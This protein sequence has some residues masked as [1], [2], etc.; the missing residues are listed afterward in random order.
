MTDMGLEDRDYMRPGGASW[1]T[2]S[3]GGR[4]LLALIAVNVAA[5]LAWQL[6][7][8]RD[9]LATHFA[10]SP[11]GLL[12]HGRVWTL[13]TS[14]FLHTSGWYLLWSLVVA[15][16]FVLEIADVYGGRNLVWLYLFGAVCAALAQVAASSLA[17]AST[18]AFAGASGPV[19]AFAATAALLFPTRTVNLL[20]MIP[21][22]L[23]VVAAAALLI[24]LMGPFEG[25]GRA[26]TLG[27]AAAGCMFKVLDLR[28]FG[29]HTPPSRVLAGHRAAPSRDVPLDDRLGPPVAAPGE[30]DALAAFSARVDDVLRKINREGL[31][32]LTPDERA[33][34]D[35][36]SRRYS[37][38]HRRV[39]TADS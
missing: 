30:D 29:A 6:P 27:G 9:L 3:P 12:E 32:S 20:G 33:L 7:G 24:D 31:A 35:E 36:A 21:V 2:S 13:V 17:G 14:G 4:A 39:T 16:V 1:A 5:F 15:V 18:V 26:A 23:W 37:G 25:A 28:L 8:M 19:M 38:R 11:A 10:A 34:L 22:P